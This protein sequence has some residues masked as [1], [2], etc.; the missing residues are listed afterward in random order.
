MGIVEEL[1]NEPPKAPMVL[2]RFGFL[3]GTNST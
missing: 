3:E 2:N 1:E